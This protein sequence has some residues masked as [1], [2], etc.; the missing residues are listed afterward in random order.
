MIEI[1][2]ARMNENYVMHN[3]YMEIKDKFKINHEKKWK[4]KAM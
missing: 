3:V 4:L 1:Q 2:R